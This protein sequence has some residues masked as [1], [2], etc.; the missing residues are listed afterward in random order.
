[1]KK[2]FA[3]LAA[4]VALTFC[5]TAQAELILL[6]TQSSGVI[7][8]VVPHDGSYTTQF[9]LTSLIGQQIDRFVLTLNYTIDKIANEWSFTLDNGQISGLTGTFDSLVGPKD[10]SFDMQG[11]VNT[12]ILDLTLVFT[13]TPGQNG[14]S[15]DNKFHLEGA[16][17]E[18][19][20]DNGST[21]TTDV[22][23]PAT[24]ALLGIGLL[25]A[26]GLRRKA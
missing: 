18:A 8:T 7:Q 2:K 11:F 25:G 22:P 26:V 5:G 15:N 1:M 13:R 23:E 3:T 12:G 21:P 17:L 4:A 19:W 10:F 16:K 24:L 20:G 9:D 6:G 14:N